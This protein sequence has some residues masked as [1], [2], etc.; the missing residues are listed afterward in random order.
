MKKFHRLAAE[1]TTLQHP[2][3]LQVIETGNDVDA[4]GRVIHFL[5]TEPV[6][7]LTLAAG[8]M[9]AGLP[10]LSPSS[11][12][13]LGLSIS[14]SSSNRGPSISRRAARRTPTILG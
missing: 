11:I 2:N 6:P 12:I 9:A 1:A 13:T 7:G 3:V 4:K 5:A 8:T 10:R 14:R